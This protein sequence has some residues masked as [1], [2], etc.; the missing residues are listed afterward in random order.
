MTN[1]PVMREPGTVASTPVAP[2]RE[3]GDGPSAE[4]QLEVL[5]WA[6]KAGIEN[7]KT[8]LES[9]N[10]LT[11]AANNLVNI[12]LAGVA[13]SL[14]FAVKVLE[15]SSPAIAWGSLAACIHLVAVCIY[16]V[17]AVLRA[18]PLPSLYNEPKNLGQPEWTKAALLREE[19]RLM[20]DRIHELCDRNETRAWRLNASRLAAVL[21]AASF[22]VAT[23]L[24]R[25]YGS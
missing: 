6:E 21:T 14:T 22:L 24:A 10:L 3:P 8:H 4:Q 12:L 19:L 2:S 20:N 25:Y 23:A 7:L 1:E 11:T 18:G 5:E 9:A 15:P 13:G 16:V 17:L